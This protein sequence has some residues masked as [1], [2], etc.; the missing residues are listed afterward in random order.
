MDHGAEVRASNRQGV[1]P[2]SS[3]ALGGFVDYVAGVYY[4]R[5]TNESNF[6]NTTLPLSGVVRWT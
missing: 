5:E 3:A 6:A 1:Q 4:F 2:L